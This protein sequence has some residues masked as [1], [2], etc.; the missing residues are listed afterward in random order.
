MTAIFQ[1]RSAVFLWGFAAIWLTMLIA[2]TYV[3]LRDGSPA[4]SS[5]PTFALVMVLFWIGGIGLGVF[6][7]TRPCSSTTVEEG[8]FV[9]VT[10]RYPHKVIRK[11]FAVASVLPAAVI[12][13]RDSDGAL[14]YYARI[15]TVEGEVVDITEGHRRVSCEKACERFNSALHPRF[16]ERTE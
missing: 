14:Y 16:L 2:M 3:A 13:S 8:R 1:N 9:T 6:V 7:S 12:E 5:A 11:V 10:W 4:G 15:S